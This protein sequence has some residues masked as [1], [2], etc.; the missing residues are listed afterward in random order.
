MK[1]ESLCFNGANECEYADDPI[2]EINK[3]LGIQEKLN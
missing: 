3:I 1:L 2:K